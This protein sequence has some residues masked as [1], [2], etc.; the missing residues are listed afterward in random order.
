MTNILLMGLPGG[1]EWTFILLI[2]ILGVFYF[3]IRKGSKDKK[4][5]ESRNHQKNSFVNEVKEVK[6]DTPDTCPHC[7]NPNT[8]KIRLCEWCGNQI[9]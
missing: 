9:I 6:I 7:K 3:F 4:N 8:K 2:L 1:S 5:E